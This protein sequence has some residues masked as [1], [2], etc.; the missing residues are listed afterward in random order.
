MVCKEGA[1][2][3]TACARGA[4]MDTPPRHLPCALI[5]F[6]LREALAQDVHSAA[7]LRWPLLR[8]VD[9]WSAAGLGRR[10]RS[11]RVL[12]KLLEPLAVWVG[13]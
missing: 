4:A 2:T 9:R 10:V 13:S 11:V 8:R 3:R 6:A 12:E 7:G 1:A 5:S